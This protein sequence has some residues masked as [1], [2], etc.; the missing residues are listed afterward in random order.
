M[1]KLRD[2]A[3]E[4]NDLGRKIVAWKHMQ[5]TFASLARHSRVDLAQNTRPSLLAR[6]VGPV[7]AL[8]RAHR[9]RLNEYGSSLSE[10]GK[11][12]VESDIAK[13]VAEGA[14]AGTDGQAFPDL[15]ELEAIARSIRKGE[16]TKKESAATA[17]SLSKANED[18]NKQPAADAE[19][20]DKAKEAAQEGEADDLNPWLKD[21][22]E[23]SE[24]KQT[25]E[26]FSNILGLNKKA[27]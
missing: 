18:A 13:Q 16:T 9:K 10:A 17:E 7:Y 6:F 1:L 26:A 20:L 23:A 27:N 11:R 21:I 12:Y 19:A 22:E 15:A 25:G 8:Q 2:P 5:K 14:D 24:H 3:D 4:T